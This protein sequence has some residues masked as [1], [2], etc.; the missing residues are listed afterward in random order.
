MQL[1][2]QRLNGVDIPPADP[3]S[4][5][6]QHFSS[7][8]DKKELSSL[9]GLNDD[10]ASDSTFV[11]KCIKYLYKENIGVLLKKTAKGTNRRIIRKSDGNFIEMPPKGALSPQ[12]IAI[13]SSIF[14][15]RITAMEISD[16]Q[17]LQR[18]AFFNILLSR[19]ID[20]I[21]KNI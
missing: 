12:K 2:L 7:Y 18:Q 8:F 15:S 19:G 6:F 3:D 9:R 4:D 13:M 1:E 17:K 16:S 10:S 5:Q 20:N 11:R 14:D 21:C